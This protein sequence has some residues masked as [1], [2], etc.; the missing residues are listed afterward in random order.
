MILTDMPLYISDSEEV[1]A[2]IASVCE[3]MDPLV[4]PV[5][6]AAIAEDMLLGVHAMDFPL[7]GSIVASINMV[8]RRGNDEVVWN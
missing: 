8:A 7:L 5:E 2:L 4:D 6:A 3:L 1:A